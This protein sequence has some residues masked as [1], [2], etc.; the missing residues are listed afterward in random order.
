MY[1]KSFF[2]LSLLLS[3]GL[4]FAESPE[5]SAAEERSISQEDEQRSQQERFQKWMSDLSPQKRD[6]MLKFI[7]ALAKVNQD[8]RESVIDLTQQYSDVLQLLVEDGF[9]PILSEPIVYE[10]APDIYEG[11]A[12]S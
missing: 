5:Q 9:K 4:A 12:N 10:G 7:A 8:H 1:K 2:A 11:P 6:E 3:S